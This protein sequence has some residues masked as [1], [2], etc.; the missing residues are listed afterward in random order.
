[1][2]KT[3]S[4]NPHRSFR[5]T[6]NEEIKDNYEA[7]G[8]MQL[9]VDTFRYIFK[10]WKI[11]GGLIL[12]TMVVII[13]FVG[14][15]SEGSMDTIRESIQND[16]QDG[17]LG[18]FAMSGLLLVSTITTGGLGSV[19][20]DAQGLILVMA[21]LI[22]FL[23]ATYVIRHRLA[24]KKIGL[25]T[26]LYNAMTPAVSTFVVLMTILVELLPVILVVIFY[27][28]A[29]KT[30]FLDTPFY[31]LM[32]VIFAFLMILLSGYLV[33]SS[34]IAL[35]A[36]TAPGVYPIPALKMS[37]ELVFGR[38][39]KIVVRLLALFLIIAVV[40]TVIMM[41]VI[42]IDTAL[43]SV[44]EIFANIP[45]VSFFLLFSMFFSFLFS[46]IYVYLIYRSLLDYKEE[47]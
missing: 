23:T 26:A 10:D 42:L 25:R 20:S 38:R 41:P 4:R 2:P 46:S 40:D 3:N 33:S 37:R 11:F 32:F 15:L 47:D 22:I 44:V 13:L 17:E 39:M 34:V 18:T 14:L 5:R 28:S 43:K 9:I 8:A 21:F 30:D 1:M 45:V 7:P 6:Y 19:F 29:I 27:S 24:E 31:A 36:T 12:I 16:F 35:I